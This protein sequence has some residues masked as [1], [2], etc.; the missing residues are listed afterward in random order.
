MKY[1]LQ[2]MNNHMAGRAASV[3]SPFYPILLGLGVEQFVY[4]KS[5]PNVNLGPSTQQ[6]IDLNLRRAK[7]SENKIYIRILPTTPFKL[8][9]EQK[10]T[11]A[12]KYYIKFVWYQKGDESIRSYKFMHIFHSSSVLQDLISS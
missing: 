8:I 5:K 1:R 11:F 6:Y 7:C 4:I 9:S 12:L 3:I 2:S 10:C